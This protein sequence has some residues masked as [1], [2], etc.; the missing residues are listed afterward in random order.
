[1]KRAALLL[2]LALSGCSAFDKCVKP[3]TNQ[4]TWAGTVTELGDVVGAFLLCDPSFS[5]GE[6]PACALQGLE[7]LSV[8]LGPDGKAI[9]DCLVAY[10]VGSANPTQSAAAKAVGV[11]RGIKLSCASPALHRRIASR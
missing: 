11:K 5:G 3:Y 8:S 4:I 1:M 6:A 7:T 2:L 10:Y 9:V